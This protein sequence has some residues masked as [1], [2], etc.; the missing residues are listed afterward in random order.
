[1]TT[2]TER[3]MVLLHAAGSAVAAFTLSQ[4]VFFQLLKGERLSL[5]EAKRLLRE[6]IAASAVGG[7]GSQFAAENLQ[8][9]LLSLEPTLSA[10]Q[11]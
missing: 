6:A 8:A 9:V 2:E 1:M 10:R 11:Q 7:P 5:E 3:E 4:I